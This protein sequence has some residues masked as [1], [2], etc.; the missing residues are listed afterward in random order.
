MSTLHAIVRNEAKQRLADARYRA[1]R[2]RERVTALEQLK[3]AIAA[4]PAPPSIADE[5]F[6][7]EAAEV[8]VPEPAPA[9][10]EPVE[11]GELPAAAPNLASLV[12][13]PEDGMI[14][15]LG[16][17]AATGAS[18]PVISDVD[19][20]PSSIAAPDVPT[21]APK[22]PVI[23]P[24]PAIIATSYIPPP[25]P[26]TELP[27]VIVPAAPVKNAVP[28]MTMIGRP[29]SGT[30]PSGVIPVGRPIEGSTVAAPILRAV[31]KKASI[32]PADALAERHLADAI[33]REEEWRRIAEAERAAQSAPPVP[34]RAS[35]AKELRRRALEEMFAAIAEERHFLKQ[36]NGV[37]VVGPHLLALFGLSQ[38]DM[39]EAAMLRRL[40]ELADSQAAEISQ[41]ATHVRASPHDIVPDGDG[42]RLGDA[43]PDD[44]R[45]LVAAWR[46]DSTMQQA[47]GRLVA[48]RSDMASPS[49][50]ARTAANPEG[51]ARRE[52]DQSGANE[53]R[54][55]PSVARRFLLL[56]G[57][58]MRD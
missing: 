19:A 3:L 9:A 28:A 8:V 30:V 47:L 16:R 58:G 41:I 54:N 37:V 25:V 51:T 10:T 1:K 42:W 20:A 57:R 15:M 23:D 11:T 53:T 24:L 56:P 55:A 38:S 2:A 34:A 27:Y 12:A 48:T 40:S 52:S 7:L 21:L 4:A 43:A 33:A 22:A 49:I 14:V 31:G 35:S 45:L 29:V 44:I 50:G 36:Q 5:L 26:V 17:A 39:T 6:P 32:D 13:G 46:N 18:P